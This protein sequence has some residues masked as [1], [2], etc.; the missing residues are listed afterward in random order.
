MP[1]TSGHRKAILSAFT[2]AVIFTTTFIFHQTQSFYKNFTRGAKH[3]D[4]GRYHR[5]LPFLVS[6]Y[7]MEPQN[8]KGATLL[9][10]CY[11]RLGM[12]EEAKDV[13]ETIWCAKPGDIGVMEELADA[14]YGLED[15]GRAEGLYRRILQ[16]R[17][18]VRVEKKLAEVLVWQK[19]Y[20]EAK[21]LLQKLMRTKARDLDFM[22]FIA[23][24]YSWSKEHDKAIELYEKLLSYGRRTD[25]ITLKLAD[26]L[27]YA[28]RNEEAI[29]LYN[30]Y[31]EQ[32]NK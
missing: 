14:L 13:L 4:A 18:G 5:A 24:I 29:E 15:Y 27:R 8:M 26:E 30:R 20:E 28:G 21:P 17:R 3:F 22:E 23:D 9:L 16:E 12:R 11:T 6:A 19:K 25:D 32:V 10:W 31:I 2:L 1:I 7:K